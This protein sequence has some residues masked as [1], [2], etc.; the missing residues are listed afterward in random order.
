MELISFLVVFGCVMC[1]LVGSWLYFRHYQL[2]RVPIGVMNLTDIAVMVIAIVALPF[3]YL[4]LPVWVVAAFLLLSA[5]GVLS[6]AFQ[7][8]LPA[9][10][11]RWMVWLVALAFLL[12]DVAAM[13]VFTAGQNAFFA[14]ND[15]VL[16]LLVVGIA[17]LW[18]QSGVKARDMAILALAV[19][20]YDVLATTQSPLMLRLLDRL[21]ALPLAPVIA[22]N[23]EGATLVLGLGDL[24]LASVFPLVMRKAFG[25]RAGGIALA[26]A[27]LVIAVVLAYP[28]RQG[29]PVMLALGPLMV[30][31]FLY[32]R[33]NSGHERT[34]KRYLLEEPLRA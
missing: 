31:Q 17:N 21:S 33:W 2:S 8:M 19:A 1:A 3:L 18:A 16:L 26:L 34:T 28:Q 12:L 25:R 9:L 29:F 27:L 22:W 10:R 7:P 30:A 32:W 14:I 13:E 15:L 23:S 5:F 4:M 24:L 11:A 20:I 6:F